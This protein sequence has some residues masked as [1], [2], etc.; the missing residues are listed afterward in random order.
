ML[1]DLSTCCKLDNTRVDG[2]LLSRTAKH[3]MS[4]RHPERASHAVTFQKDV[5]PT[6]RC[7]KVVH[8]YTTAIIAPLWS[9]CSCDHGWSGTNRCMV[10]WV[11]CGSSLFRISARHSAA[12]HFASMKCM[13]VRRTL[14]PKYIQRCHA[15]PAAE[16]YM[17][18]M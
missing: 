2:I 9:N 7:V 13:P 14:H 5:S 4:V 16:T 18:E 1:T 8:S 12:V 11:M 6:W 10:M 17:L 3:C 15:A